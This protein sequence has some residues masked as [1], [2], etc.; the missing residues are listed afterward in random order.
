MVLLWSF[1]I[2]LIIL[3]VEIALAQNAPIAWTPV[4][5]NAPALP[6]AVRNPYLNTWF[7]QGNNPEPSGSLWPGFWSSVVSTFNLT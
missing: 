3:H 2:V 5:F 6:L 1:H 4:P 7:S